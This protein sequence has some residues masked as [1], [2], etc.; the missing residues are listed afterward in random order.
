MAKYYDIDDIITDEEIAAVIF[1]KAASGLGIDP[2]SETDCADILLRGYFWWNSLCALQVPNQVFP[3]ICTLLVN[4][5]SVK[6][7]PIKCDVTE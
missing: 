2:S 1:Q 3:K 5:S 4:F 6:T 7:S